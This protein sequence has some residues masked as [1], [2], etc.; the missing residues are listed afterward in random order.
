MTRCAA[1]IV[2]QP[3]PSSSPFLPFSYS[4]FS[5]SPPPSLV[6]LLFPSCSPSFN[7]IPLPHTLFLPFPLLPFPLLLPY[8]ESVGHSH[9]FP[10]AMCPHMQIHSPHTYSHF[11][12]INQSTNLSLSPSLSLSPFLSLSL[13]FPLSLLHSLSLTL[14]SVLTCCQYSS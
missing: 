2:R 1:L 10:Y 4:S 7:T 14:A 13:P 3:L 12:L 9:S 8:S 5:Y 6:P 11:S